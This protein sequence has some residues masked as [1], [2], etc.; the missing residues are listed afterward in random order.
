MGIGHL[1]WLNGVLDVNRHHRAVLVINHAFG[2]FAVLAAVAQHQIAGVNVANRAG[3]VLGIDEG[4][5]GE[6][7]V[8]RHC[9][10]IDDFQEG[11]NA[12]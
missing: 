4:V 3:A 5:G 12:L 7:L 2:H 10:V 11:H 6:T 9:G 8:H 1:Q